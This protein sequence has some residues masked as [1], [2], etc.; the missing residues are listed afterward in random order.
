MRLICPSCQSE[1]EVDAAAIGAK[2]RMVRCANCGGEWFQAPEAPADEPEI[3]ADAPVADGYAAAA[4]VDHE[5]VDAAEQSEDPGYRI[6]DETPTASV[7]YDEEPAVE[8]SFPA[9]DDDYVPNRYAEARDTDALAASLQDDD[10]IRPAS[11]KGAASFFGGFATSAVL[12]GLFAAIYVAAPSIVNAVP[13]LEPAMTSYVGV[14]EQGRTVLR[15]LVG[16]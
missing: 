10:D 3:E 8:R 9:D 4:S 12:V 15:V 14:V 5:G 6:I 2:G 16:G 13:A 1:Y 7:T 11:N